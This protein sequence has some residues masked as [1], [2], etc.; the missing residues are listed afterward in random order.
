MS[1]DAVEL[2]HPGTI[3]GYT[4]L[5]LRATA[6][7]ASVEAICQVSIAS[8]ERLTDQDMELEFPGLMPY[9]EL[10]G[11][12]HELSEDPALATANTSTAAH[13]GFYAGSFIGQQAVRPEPWG[14]SFYHVPE[15]MD[16]FRDFIAYVHEAPIRYLANRPVLRRL[17]QRYVPEVIGDRRLHITAQLAAGLALLHTDEYCLKEF[18]E[19]QEVA[20]ALSELDNWDGRI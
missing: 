7:A 15:K 19:E 18:R 9:V 8:G 5:E 6:A 13:I 4:D 17:V 14:M 20:V 1:V 11:R 12:A 16:D 10:V 3:A 2:L